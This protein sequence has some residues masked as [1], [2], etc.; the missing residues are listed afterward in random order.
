MSNK[1]YWFEKMTKWLQVNKTNSDNVFVRTENLTLNQ[2]CTYG[3]VTIQQQQND[4][5][6]RSRTLIFLLK[7]TSISL[8]IHTRGYF[9]Y[10]ELLLCKIVRNV[11]FALTSIV[12]SLWL[13]L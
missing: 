3:T 2:V 4:I 9:S 8:L 6:S 13:A 7:I 12:F 10:N 1:K 5:I 11:P